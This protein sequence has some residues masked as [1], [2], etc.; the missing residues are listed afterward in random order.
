MKT[1]RNPP[2][3]TM[4]DTKKNWLGAR[5]HRNNAGMVKIAPAATASP[6]VVIVCTMLFSRIDLRRKIPRR[7][8]NEITADGIEALTVKPILSP[9]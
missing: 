7:M 3:N 1:P 8:A 6:A 4:N 9:R 2:V 5:F